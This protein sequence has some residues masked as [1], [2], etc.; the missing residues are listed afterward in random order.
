MPINLTIGQ[1]RQVVYFLVNTPTQSATATREAVGTGKN[2]VYAVLLT[3]RGRLRKNN[4][5]RQMLF[6]MVESSETYDLICRFQSALAGSLR[7]DM[8]IIIDQKTYTP[9]AWEKIDE[10]N[11]LYKFTLNTSTEQIDPADYPGIG[12]GTFVVS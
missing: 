3:T 9:A 1:M 7:V 2:D 10:I 4:G 11:H 5:N 6:G 12:I 8:K